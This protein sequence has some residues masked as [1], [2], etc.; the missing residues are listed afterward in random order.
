[1][2][3]AASTRPHRGLITCGDDMP[4]NVSNELK[5]GLFVLAAVAAAL[6][7][8][9]WLGAADIFKRTGQQVYFYG[10]V[11]AGPMG[12]T[13]GAYVMLGDAPIGQ[14]DQVTAEPKNNRCVYRARL[15]RRDITIKADAKAIVSS[16]FIGAARIAIE[17]TGQAAHLA[18]G[19]HPILLSGGMEQAMGELAAAAEH[20]N[21]ITKTIQMELSLGQSA[22]LLSKLHSLIGDLQT[23]ST[24]INVLS[25]NVLHQTD[26]EKM[27]S[28]M[29]R[30]RSAMG[31]ITAMT[32][33]ARPKM[34]QMMT[35]L[36]N[37]ASQIESYTKK[38]VA[39]LLAGLRK[40]ND[41][42][43]K[44]ANDFSD[45][46]GQTRQIVVMN[47][48]NIDEIIDNMTSVSTNLKATAKEVR[49]NPWRLLYKP[50]KEELRSQNIYD[51]TRAFA[52][53]AEQLDQ[54]LAK[55]N[56]LSKAS[57]QGVTLN[58]PEMVKVRQQILDT[59]SKFNK[60]EEALWKELS[61]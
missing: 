30:I 44:I 32:S 11:S 18:D 15:A 8:I 26:P 31:D 4:K 61:R 12:I 7:I 45:V 6:G 23:A 52:A 21:T 60:A 25:A 53:G 5:A 49:R 59:F 55:L 47:R 9:L 48:D 22:S 13:Q 14:I 1:M 17:S 20:V 37:S 34:A 2:T 16:P 38:D 29:A 3:P 36:N 50:E 56:A 28:L 33:D 51:A 40:T 35:S 10:P 41:Q 46:S 57:P 27:D 19:Q 39:E 43:L 58:D 24:N 42:I 54:S